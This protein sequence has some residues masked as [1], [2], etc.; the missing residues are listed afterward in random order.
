MLDLYQKYSPKKLED[1]DFKDKYKICIDI[2]SHLE[3]NNI[4]NILFSGSYGSG[5]KT[6]LYSFLGQ[7]KKTKYIETIKVN[8]ISVDVILYK[9]KKY[10]EIDISTVGIYKQHIFKDLLKKISLYKDVNNQTKIIVIHNVHILDIKDQF[11]LRKIIE[12][13]ITICRFILLGENINNLI[14]PIVSRCLVL[15]LPD[16]EITDIIKKIKFVIDKEN[17]TITDAEFDTIIKNAGTDLK[18]ALLEL[19]TLVTCHKTNVDY[20]SFSENTVIITYDKL[21]ELIKKPQPN[22]TSIDTILYKLFVNYEQLGIDIMKKLFYTLKNNFDST[23]KKY[24]IDLMFELSKHI[25]GVLPMTQL[26]T[27]VYELNNMFI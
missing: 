2:L 9:T 24:I 26:Q 4:P 10:I 11:I 23:Q 22:Y 18:K 16:L 14:E 25:D 13:N 8:N 15:R 27:F 1:L 21:I 12:E 20:I 6:I 3:Y 5:K 17:I 19:Q 7:H